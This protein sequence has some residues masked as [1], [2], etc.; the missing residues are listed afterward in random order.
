VLQVSDR[1]GMDRFSEPISLALYVEAPEKQPRRQ[2]SAR[3][4]LDLSSISHPPEG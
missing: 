2:V 1:G 3:P 4:P